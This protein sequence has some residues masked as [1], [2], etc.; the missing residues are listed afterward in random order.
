M[1]LPAQAAVGVAW[2]AGANTWVE[3]D[4]AYAE[5]SAFENIDVDIL[6]ET[7][8]SRDFVIEENWDDTFSYRIGVFWETSDT[9]EWRFGGVFDESPVPEEYL[10]PSIPDADR[11]GL[12]VGYGYTGNRWD[13]DLYYMALSFDD[14]TA[15]TGI[16]GVIA[17]TY[18]TFV[19]LAGASFNLRF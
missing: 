13:V 3:I 17:G 14:I 11:T 19:H 16:E 6:N 2:Q 8:F 10:R 15:V 4:V 12:T 5:W 18:E 9:S 7:V 1:N